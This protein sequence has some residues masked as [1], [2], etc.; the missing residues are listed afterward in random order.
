MIE[1]GLNDGVQVPATLDLYGKPISTADQAFAQMYTQLCRFSTKLI[2]DAMDVV[3]TAILEYS[4]PPPVY[5]STEEDFLSPI[6]FVQVVLATM[7]KGFW[8]QKRLY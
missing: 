1:S 2:P 4:S 6:R 5:P 3:A 7:I 8:E